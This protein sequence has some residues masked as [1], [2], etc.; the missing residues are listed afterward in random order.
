[1]SS[2]LARLMHGK[3]EPFSLPSLPSFERQTIRDVARGADTE[4]PTVIL[5]KL[6]K[7]APVFF[8]NYDVGAIRSEIVKCLRECGT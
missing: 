7:T 5:E 2:N 8:K 3:T 4:D 6:R 1:M